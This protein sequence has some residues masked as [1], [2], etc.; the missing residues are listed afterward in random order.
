MKLDLFHRSPIT[1]HTHAVLIY[2][3]YE[4]RN[5]LQSRNENLLCFLRCVCSRN[6]RSLYSTRK[7]RKVGFQHK[8][9]CGKSIDSARRTR[10]NCQYTRMYT[11]YL[12]RRKRDLARRGTDSGGR[13]HIKIDDISS[14][15]FQFQD[16]TGA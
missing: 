5:P 9:F 11:Y 15:L 13:A 10:A 6:Y 8:M 12:S 16:S 4:L 2:A 7:D 3:L 14:E 1:F